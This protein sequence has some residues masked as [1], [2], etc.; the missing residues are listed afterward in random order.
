MFGVSHYEWMTLKWSFFSA[1]GVQ[2][3]NS[4]CQW[5]AQAQA[6]EEIYQTLLS[7]RN[8]GYID[9]VH[10]DHI[11]KP[12]SFFFICQK[13]F[14]NCFITVGKNISRNE[15]PGPTLMYV[16]LDLS[17][18]VIKRHIPLVSQSL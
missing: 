5:E 13:K 1:V 2:F 7:N 16:N 10:A 18:H 15:K 12:T 3:A 17:I 14:I 9:T 11:I 8:L 6:A 4:S